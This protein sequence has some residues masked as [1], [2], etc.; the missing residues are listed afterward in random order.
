ML[1]VVAQ[2]LLC[3]SLCADFSLSLFHRCCLQVVARRPG[4]SELDPVLG[5]VAGV[6]LSKKVFT[7]RVR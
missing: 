6:E 2:A 4:F 3:N 1:S 7:S 5:P